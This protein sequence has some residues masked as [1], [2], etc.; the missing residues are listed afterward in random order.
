MLKRFPFCVILFCLT[1]AVSAEETIRF[2]M[3]RIDTAR[4]EAC[5]VA[6]FNNDGKLDIVAGEFIYLAPDWKAVKIREIAGD[7]DEQGKGYAHDF[8]NLPMDVD[9]D[10]FMDV[11]A[12]D[13]FSKKSV[14]CRN[15]G[16]DFQDGKFWEEHLIELNGNF[17]CADFYDVTGNGQEDQILPAVRHTVWYEKTAP[18][19]FAVHVVSEKNLTFGGGVGDINGDGRPDILRPDVWFEAPVDIRNGV[20]KE[21]PLNLFADEPEMTNKDTAQLYALDVNKDGLPDIIAS[22][23]HDYGLFWYEQLRNGDGISWKKHVIDK[24]WSQVHAVMLA[25]LDGDGEFEIIAGK[26]FMAHNG[27]DR[28]EY[29]P[30]GIY[31]Y[32]AK[33]NG[34]EVIWER[35][36]VTYDEGIGAGMNI[37]VVDLNGDGHLDIVTTGKYG[38]PVWFENLK[39]D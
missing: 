31:Y 25:D 1:V 38:G 36:V 27:S 35:H 12:V 39:N 21:H 28:G 14:W 34:T 22:A 37:V 10:G 26:R 29:E 20:W 7:V 2:K 8:A 23:A 5:G 18:G 30:L 15:P 32:K 4:M 16:K 6:D 33:R 3:H 17:E 19:K 11:I 24:S 9:E 13:W